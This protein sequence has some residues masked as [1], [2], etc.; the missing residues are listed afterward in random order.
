MMLGNKYL[1][2]FALLNI[3]CGGPTRKPVSTSNDGSIAHKVLADGLNYPWEILWGPD[4]HIWM[5]EREG[6]I[7]RVDPG[8]GKVTALLQ[9]PGTVAKGEGGLLGMVLHPNFADTP[10][11]FVACNYEGSKGYQEKI[12]RYTYNGTTLVD[13]VV[14]F[15]NIEAA[16]IHNGCRLLILPDR[17][18]LFSTGDASNQSLPQNKSSVNGKMLRI[19]LDGSIP[20]DN[21]LPGSPVW[22]FGHRNIQGLVMAHSRIYAS[23]HGPDTDD[24]VNL[25]NKGANY[26]WPTVKGFCDGKREQVFC[27]ENKVQEP[28][29]AWTPTIAVCGLDYYADG[30]I[31]QWKNSLLMATLKDATLYQLPLDSGYNKITQANTFLSHSISPDGKVYLC[32]SNGDNTDKLI[33]VEAR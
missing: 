20:A 9:V 26:G 31:K 10:H 22:S 3:S 32:T 17:T 11:L 29:Y 16:Y 1:L 24:E 2:L 18:L 33:V 6:R 23:E 12:I 15:D 14:I 25:I 19:R 21:P 7:S 5:T 8:T 13:P 4:N 28:M 27:R 30:P